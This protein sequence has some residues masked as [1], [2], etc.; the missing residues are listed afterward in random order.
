MARHE[1]L[2][3]CKAAL[4]FKGFAGLLHAGASGFGGRTHGALSG[5]L[6]WRRDA[7]PPR[8]FV[9]TYVRM[10]SLGVPALKDTA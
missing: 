5:D 4:D 7:G 6:F 8:G 10:R 9:Y 1:H 3:I 2:P